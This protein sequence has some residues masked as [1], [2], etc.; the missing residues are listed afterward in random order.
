MCTA[1]VI[2]KSLTKE[3]EY[4]L[5]LKHRDL[6][7]TNLH[8][9][10]NMLIYQ[11]SKKFGKDG[12]L[13][14]VDCQSR[15]GRQSLCGTNSSGFAIINTATYNLGQ[16]NFNIQ[17]PPSDVM[18][19]ALGTCETQSDFDNLLY[20]FKGRLS[21]ANYGIID[22]LGNTVYYEVGTS[23]IEKLDV[24]ISA[25]KYVAFTNFSRCGNE[26]HPG[27]E[28]YDSANG[29]IKKSLE[30]NKYISPELLFDNVSRSFK[31][32]F[33]GLD[34]R[35]DGNPLGEYFIDDVFIPSRRT[36][37][38]VIFQGKTIWAALGYPPTSFVV[39]IV[40]AQSLPGFMCM[41]PDCNASL[42]SEMSLELK[43]RVF[44]INTG[45]GNRYFNFSR[46]YNREGTGI[47]Q[48]IAAVEK[49]MYENFSPELRES[50]LSAFY[51]E[52]FRKINGVYT[53]I[54][55]RGWNSDVPDEYRACGYDDKIDIQT[56]NTTLIRRVLK[57]IML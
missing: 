19:K 3:K 21:P 5:L 43:K 42:M 11:S 31:S 39:P 15:N 23:K 12:I 2:S 32:A 14:V 26:G 56:D 55:R 17:I 54:L 44:D 16:R 34:L 10:G 40:F 6:S 27:L 45:E 24:G 8:H 13:S 20:S 36:S 7:S 57:R 47:S 30:D 49:W 4:P 29:Q 33:F 25:D 53:D 37:F 28:R 48:R 1:A 18:Y 46:L 22:S 9:K 51:E 35:K 38:S 41:S 52:Y 50:A